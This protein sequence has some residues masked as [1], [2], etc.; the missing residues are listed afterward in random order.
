MAA[1][2]WMLTFYKADIVVLRTGFG[3]LSATVALERVA[4]G[5][6]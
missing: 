2:Y 6:G 1:H 5:G 3:E 4:W